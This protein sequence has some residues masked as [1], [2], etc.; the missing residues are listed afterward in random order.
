[1]AI[2]FT[3]VQP[4]DGETLVAKNTEVIINV[5][6][7]VPLNMI[8]P[9]SLTISIDGGTGYVVAYETSVFKNGWTGEVIDNNPGLQNDYTFILLRPIV[10]PYYI[11]DALIYVKASAALV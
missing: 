9:A 5:I 3:L 11:E 6:E 10:D 4:T 1:M 2:V 8:D 7:N